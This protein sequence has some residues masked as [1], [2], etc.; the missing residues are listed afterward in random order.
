MNK[1][2]Q[3]IETVICEHFNLTAEQ[4]KQKTRR[5]EIVVPR[6]YAMFFA[7]KYKYNGT[8]LREIGEYFGQTHATVIH[9]CNMRQEGADLYPADRKVLK[10]LDLKIQNSGDFLKVKIDE[11]LAEHGIENRD[12]IVSKIMEFVK[13]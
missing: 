1:T 5:R 8:P 10:I 12:E 6:Q 7:E 11:I 4:L 3:E 13:I 2:T 9:A